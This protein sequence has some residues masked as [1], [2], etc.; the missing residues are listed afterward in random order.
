MSLPAP[1]E[2]WLI[3]ELGDSSSLMALSTP[4]GFQDAFDAQLLAHV[5]GIAVQNG[6]QA[7]GGGGD[8]FLMRDQDAQKGFLQADIAG[9]GF[10]HQRGEGWV[11]EIV[12]P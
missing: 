9:D 7:G 3:G 5:A 8:D 6:R 1:G 11:V 12:P 10:L 4:M 2:T